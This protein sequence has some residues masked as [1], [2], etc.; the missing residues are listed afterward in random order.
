MAFDF[1]D[2]NMYYLNVIVKDLG[3]LT[4]T[5]QVEIRVVDTNES[6]VFLKLMGDIDENSPENT[7]I[8]IAHDTISTDPEGDMVM[9]R[10]NTTTTGL[11]FAFLDNQLI[12]SR[13]QLNY[14]VTS[15]YTFT[16]EACDSKA[17]CTYTTFTILVNDVNEPPVVF[18]SLVS[19]VENALEGSLVGSPILASDPDLGQRLLY[20]ITDTD[21]HDLFGIQP[22][23][24]QIY[25]K[26]SYSLDFERDSTY[27]ILVN[28]SD[29]GSPSLT[30][31][32]TI[33]VAIRDV[34]EAPIFTTDYT[35]HT[36]TTNVSA[37]YY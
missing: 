12:V 11:P 27:H 3:G 26:R 28:V 9:Y 7:T 16:I 31:S 29:S 19:I 17:L 32:A 37:R 36:Y 10:I 1:E 23:N 5:K 15:K 34:N 6:P 30:S 22:C 13:A 18:P 33:T 8:L 14:E 4:D 21:T 25:V 24:G 35:I 2:C 20:S